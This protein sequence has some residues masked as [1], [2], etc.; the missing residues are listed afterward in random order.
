MKKTCQGIKA[1]GAR[2]SSPFVGDGRFCGAHAPGASERMSE[3][4]RAGGLATAA[5]HAAT[6]D[7]DTE[8]PPLDS[9]EAAGRWYEIIARA[10]SGGRITDKVAAQMTKA[11]DG[12]VKVQGHLTAEKAEELRRILD[13]LK[14]KRRRGDAA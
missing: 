11:V 9:V 4:G 7:A 2:C 8:L 1:D 14:M 3:R 12:F 10:V 5:K 6:F 13:E